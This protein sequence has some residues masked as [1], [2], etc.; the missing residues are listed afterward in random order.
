M[1][2]PFNERI[3]S[4]SATGVVPKGSDA[5]NAAFLPSSR[6]VV[7]VSAAI[8]ALQRYLYPTYNSPQGITKPPKKLVLVL[9]GTKLGRAENVDGIL[10]ILKAA[11]VTMESWF[12]SG[13]LRSA[14]VGLQFSEIIQYTA[15][16]GTAIRYIGAE[17]YDD[18]ADKYTV[19][20]RVGSG[21]NPSDL[22]F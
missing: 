13:E 3:A 20:S 14:S 2:Q 21:E 4:A 8:A 6:Y 9:P 1:D 11:N 19:S 16:E 7:N 12:P 22:S 18:L 5:F 10:C 15:G 17:K